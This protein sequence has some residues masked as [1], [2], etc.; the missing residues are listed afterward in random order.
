MGSGPV[1]ISDDGSPPPSAPFATDDDSSLLPVLDDKWMRV[2]RAHE[3]MQELQLDNGYHT[4][5]D[6]SS[7]ILGVSV[8]D[9]D[10][11]VVGQIN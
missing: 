5:T 7:V 9:Q 8:N 1:I 3:F 2:S 10:L 11:L 4:L 6:D